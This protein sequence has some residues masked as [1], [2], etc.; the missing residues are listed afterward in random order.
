MVMP[1]K[2]HTTVF[3]SCGTPKGNTEFDEGD[4]SKDARYLRAFLMRALSGAITGYPLFLQRD[5]PLLIID[6]IVKQDKEREHEYPTRST[7]L[8]V[9]ADLSQPIS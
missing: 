7:K 6:K 4:N 5:V 8:P 1:V 9:Q 2:I 3:I